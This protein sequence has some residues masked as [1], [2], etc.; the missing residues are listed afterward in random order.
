MHCFAQGQWGS[1]TGTR[2]GPLFPLR[3]TQLGVAKKPKI[4]IF[5]SFWF[6]SNVCSWALLVLCGIEKLEYPPVHKSTGEHLQRNGGPRA[7]GRR[8]LYFC[9]FGDWSFSKFSV[10]P[11]LGCF[12]LF[13]LKVVSGFKPGSIQAYFWYRLFMYQCFSALASLEAV[14]LDTLE[15]SPKLSYRFSVFLII[16]K[17]RNLR[18]FYGF[19]V[20][21][22]H[23]YASSFKVL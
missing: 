17:S 21:Q 22:R 14:T 20:I 19:T 4:E 5:F 3:V 2:Y 18:C 23:S 9:V 15:S 11:V 12:Q 13:R 8:Y 10:T 6:A 7:V 16:H 1:I